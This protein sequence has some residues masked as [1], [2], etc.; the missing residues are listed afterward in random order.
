M[1]IEQLRTIMLQDILQLHPVN[2][3]RLGI[4]DLARGLLSG[5]FRTRK[6]CSSQTFCIYPSHPSENSPP[7]SIPLEPAV[8]CRSLVVSSRRTSYLS[9]MAKS[10]SMVFILSM[11]ALFHILV[12]A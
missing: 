11:T 10:S 12:I 5:R 8:R 4:N 6:P 3:R 2:D 1:H 9:R 7:R